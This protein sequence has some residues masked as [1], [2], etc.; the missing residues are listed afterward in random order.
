MRVLSID[1][2]T[3]NLGACDVAS[4][5]GGG[6]AVLGWRVVSCDLASGTSAVDGCIRGAVGAMR[7]MCD[8]AG[9]CPWDRVVVENQPTLKN[10]RMKAVQTAIH[11]FF[12][13]RD[14]A[15]EV[16]LAGA[17]GK[18]K[19]AD[20]VLGADP[21]AA[22]LSSGAR[23]RRA[24][25]RSVRAAEVILG[26]DGRHAAWLAELAGHPKKD[27]MCDAFMQAIFFLSHKE[28]LV[29]IRSDMVRG[30]PQGGACDASI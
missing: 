19:L 16:V 8:E 24:K 1:V 27:D 12:A 30:A 23:Y 6:F 13:M 2:G 5:A 28:K 29:R 3:K 14:E 11:A 20:L 7:A 15:P 9:G 25:K 26:G 4:E 18:N 10:P 21:D 17:V 22:G